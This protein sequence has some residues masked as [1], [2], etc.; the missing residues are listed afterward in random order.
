MP[1]CFLG[2]P[3]PLTP[4]AP[5]VWTGTGPNAP[6]QPTHAFSQPAVIAQTAADP[7]RLPFVV[8]TILIKTQQAVEAATAAA[9]EAQR[10]MADREQQ[11]P[12]TQQDALMKQ[13]SYLAAEAAME[14]AEQALSVAVRLLQDTQHLVLLQQQRYGTHSPFPFFA[15]PIL[16]QQQEPIDP[17][18]QD[19][20]DSQAASTMA[21]SF[22]LSSDLSSS[23]G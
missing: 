1:T 13:Q 22:S 8:E 2:P 10:L 20:C 11:S 18:L 21:F 15:F 19:T 9:S 16:Q 7:R 14:S 4:A 6:W 17:E 5:T 3:N 12:S 23:R